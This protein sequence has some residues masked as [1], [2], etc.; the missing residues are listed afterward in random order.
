M[1]YEGQRHPGGAGGAEAGHRKDGGAGDHREGER[2]DSD[3]PQ[4]G[5]RLPLLLQILRSLVHIYSLISKSVGLSR[6]K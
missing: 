6:L 2:S 5:Q 4:S 3:S 1:C